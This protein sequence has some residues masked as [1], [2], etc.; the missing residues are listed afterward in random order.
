MEQTDSRFVKASCPA[1]Q[2]S[3]V[4]ICSSAQKDLSFHQADLQARTAVVA[5]SC[6]HVSL[7]SNRVAGGNC[8][9]EC[10][11]VEKNSTLLHMGG[12]RRQRQAG[13]GS[14]TDLSAL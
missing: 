4:T 3:I 12:E 9:S 10:A 1:K 11:R 6:V 13:V 7:L 2:T 8:V 5:G 14:Q